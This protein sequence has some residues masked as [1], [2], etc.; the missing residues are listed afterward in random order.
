M[1]TSVE[2]KY[3]SDHTMDDDFPYMKTL[4]PKVRAAGKQKFVVKNLKEKSYRDIA[5]DNRPLRTVIKED[6][7]SMETRNDGD[8]EV[9][10]RFD[11][12][13]LFLLWR[14]RWARNR[15]WA[16]AD[17]IGGERG[18]AHLQVFFQTVAIVSACHP[19]IEKTMDVCAK[20]LKVVGD[21][22]YYISSSTVPKR[23]RASV[24]N[25]VSSVLAR[26]AQHVD[27]DVTSSLRGDKQLLYE[28]LKSGL[29]CSRGNIDGLLVRLLRAELIDVFGRFA[30]LRNT[31]TTP[32]PVASEATAA[33]SLQMPSLVEDVN[34]LMFLESLLLLLMSVLPMS[35]VLSSV[36]DNGV[37]K[38]LLDSIG[39][40][41][42]MITAD[43]ALG[44][45]I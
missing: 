17:I 36:I 16:D 34:Q 33:A 12:R 30:S 22:L 28:G 15:T 41:S 8:A 29:G 7:I 44:E 38:L 1:D 32:L 9:V 10:D 19:N 3:F 27:D 14:L 21:M 25:C 23:V 39:W 26:I 31:D 20:A 5:N 35:G 45:C 13:L 40:G 4:I 42:L 37:V 18:W 24:C 6:F 43:R 11:C 2:Q